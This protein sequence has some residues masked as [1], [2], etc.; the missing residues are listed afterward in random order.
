[1][2][3]HVAMSID[4][5]LCSEPKLGTHSELDVSSHSFSSLLCL[6]VLFPTFGRKRTAPQDVRVCFTSADWTTKR[7][8]LAR[9]LILGNHQ[10]KAPAKQKLYQVSS[11]KPTTSIQ[12][13]TQAMSYVHMVSSQK[14]S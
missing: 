9:N 14:K 10:N 3:F 4:M 12:L 1:M 6:M 11:L 2:S 7:S 8:I 5:G 13:L